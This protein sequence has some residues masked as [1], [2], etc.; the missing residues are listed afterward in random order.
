[1]VTLPPEF[2]ATKFPGYFWNTRTHSLY[3]LKG[4]GVLRELPVIKPNAFNHIH[5][6]G[7]RVS[8]LGR[9]RWLTLSYLESL[10]PFDT[11]IPVIRMTLKEVIQ[12]IRKANTLREIS[13]I[14]DEAD[15]CWRYGELI[16]KDT[17]WVWI[18]DVVAKRSEQVGR[19]NELGVLEER[20]ENGNV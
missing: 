11:T 9:K 14:V 5:E 20:D 17:D 4:G 12:K 18:T 6:P 3:T 10:L 8:H 1:M 13:E 2:A 19:R 16:V 7:Y 15:A